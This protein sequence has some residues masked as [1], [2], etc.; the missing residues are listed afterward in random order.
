MFNQ[1]L[2]TSTLLDSF[3]FLM[4]APNSPI[5]GQQERTWKQQAKIDFFGKIRREKVTYPDW[6]NMGM[7]FENVVYEVCREN[8]SLDDATEAG[9]EEFKQV[10]REV[11]GGLFQNKLKK[12][13]KVGSHDAF[14]FGF[15]DVEKPNLTIDIKTCKEWKGPQKYLDKA[16]H[17]MYLLMNGKDNFKYVVAEWK[18]DMSGNPIKAINSVNIVDYRNP[19]ENVLQK[20]ITEKIEKMWD[21]I[22]SENLWDDYWFT[23]SKN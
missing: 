3:D 7:D 22:V 23:F 6:V 1:C 4:S 21:Y 10:I 16:Q 13:I 2:V 5:K 8:R 15:S 18:R 14:L 19:G 9:S 11:H 20:R 17:E 12:T